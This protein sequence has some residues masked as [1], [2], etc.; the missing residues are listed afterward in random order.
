[1]DLCMADVGVRGIVV[2]HFI[3]TTIVAFEELA[4]FGSPTPVRAVVRWFGLG[5]AERRIGRRAHEAVRLV[6]DGKPPVRIA[7]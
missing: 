6:R 1:M 4:A 3:K 5:G 2:A 7:D